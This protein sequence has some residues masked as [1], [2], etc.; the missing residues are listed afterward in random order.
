MSK[1][2]VLGQINYHVARLPLW[3]EEQLQDVQ[4]LREYLDDLEAGGVDVP[5]TWDG[6]LR[7]IL[8]SD[9]MGVSD[10]EQR[11]LR[12]EITDWTSELLA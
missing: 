7:R 3:S 1:E 5:Y 10:D 8:D 11:E 4:Y 9:G 6:R 2:Q 12:D